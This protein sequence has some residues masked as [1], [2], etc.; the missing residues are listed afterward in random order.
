M[1]GGAWYVT[2]H[3][4]AKSLCPNWAGG[5]WGKSGKQIGI[6]A[7]LGLQNLIQA[8]ASEA[9]NSKY[10]VQNVLFGVFV[11]LCSVFHL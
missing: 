7:F 4:V 5:G 9:D 2:V 8:G 1:D 6:W 3:E 11:C 10:G